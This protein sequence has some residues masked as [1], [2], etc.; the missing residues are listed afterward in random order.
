MS[1]LQ[2]GHRLTAGFLFRLTSR[3]PAAGAASVSPVRARPFASTIIGKGSLSAVLAV[4]LLALALPGGGQTD[5]QTAGLQALDHG[6]YRQAEQVFSQIAAQDPKNYAALFN[7][8]LAEIS[9]KENGK[10]EQNLRQVLALKPGLYEAELNL[11]IL[12]LRD[13]NVSQ[14]LPFLQQA[15]QAK[16]DQAACQRYL[17]EALLAQKDW[18]GATRAFSRALTLNPKL[19][20]AELG[21]GQALARAGK[22]DAAA[23][24]FR[25]ASEIDPALRSYSLELAH[26]Y[27]SAGRA[28]DALPILQQFPDDPAARE[29]SG[30]IYLERN[31]AAAAVNEF[32]AAVRLSPTPANRLALATAYLKNNQPAL[33]KPLLDQALAANPDDYD[34]RMALGRIKRDQHAYADAAA[35][36]EAAATLRPSSPE[37]WSETAAACTLASQYPQALAA[38]DRL[39]A[40]N[41]EKPGDFYVRAIILD[42]LHQIKAALENYRRFLALSNGQHPDQEFLARQRSRILQQEESR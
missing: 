26:D 41:A 34:L 4:I 16:P 5:P 28:A 39:H 22:L 35:Q 3:P 23:P 21:M 32:E 13:N 1:P 36:F 24:H 38:L 29:E 9:L 18:N 15:A 6:D 20:V 33:A 11:G 10:A 42:R 27:V 40:L 2:W 8:A 25:Q 30:R 19:A 7:L 37:A 12:Y 17:G 14:A 31:N